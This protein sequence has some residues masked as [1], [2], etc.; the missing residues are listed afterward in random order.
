MRTVDSSPS[1]SSSS[2]DF[3]AWRLRFV[4]IAIF[5]VSSCLAACT[6]KL[7]GSAPDASVADMAQ[8]AQPQ[9]DSGRPDATVD[10]AAMLGQD[11]LSTSDQTIDLALPDTAAPVDAPLV[12]SLL[13]R[14]REQACSSCGIW[15]HWQNVQA[16]KPRLI[17]VYEL[18]GVEQR[19]QVQHG[20]AGEDNGHS[21][22]LRPDATEATRDER[23]HTMLVKKT[24]ARSGL[25]RAD[26]SD[27][28][29]RA[30]IVSARLHLHLHGSEGLANSDHSS[31]LTIHE[32]PS[33]WDWD[34]VTW[35]HR[36][37]GV[38]W[39]RPGGDAGRL[40]REIHADTD[41]H[42]RGFTKAAPNGFFDLTPYLTLLQSER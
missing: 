5:V 15:F 20:L 24:P 8:L 17:V 41:M 28:P 9:Q 38:A 36:A 30:Q 4:V 18:D 34:A 22:T 19:R 35:T 40:V 2:R 25:F 1:Y 27:I 31:V 39:N 26:V 29:A 12:V 33:E 14:Q 42:K 13:F 10:A 37:P 16:Q 23:R 21:L 7:V 6:G 11:M 32:C 3:A